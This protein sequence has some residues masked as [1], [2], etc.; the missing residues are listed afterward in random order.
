MAMLSALLIIIS[1]TP[2]A[3]SDQQ[4]SF[5]VMGDSR[6]DGKATGTGQINRSVLVKLKNQII[7]LRNS[8]TTYKPEFLVFLGDMCMDGGEANINIW[9]TLMDQP[10]S[11][12]IPYFVTFGN[13][14]LYDAV[15]IPK[16]GKQW[17]Y[18]EDFARLL[19][20]EPTPEF[21]TER[22]DYLTNL[23]FSFRKGNA[24]FVIL[25]AYNVRPWKKTDKIPLIGYISNGQ[26][27]WLEGVL[28]KASNDDSI[29]HKF[30]FSHSPLDCMTADSDNCTKS[31]Y[32][33]IKGALK[34]Y[35]VDAFFAGHDH[36]FSY[37]IYD[38]A[39]NKKGMGLTSGRAGA[40]PHGASPYQR[41]VVALDH[42]IYVK[43]DGANWYISVYGSDGVPKYQFN[44]GVKQ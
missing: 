33:P 42:F 8:L 23:A 43:I 2:A 3:A 40:L 37:Y 24:L 17:T 36:V 27:D 5:V 29:K 6:G 21:Y 39:N 7:N 12:G 38:T 10:L 22:G 9:K 34:T 41:D 30:V 11:L 44:N 16:R 31:Y 20:N 35:N 18:Q 25:D 26:Y 32:T 4:F 28:K 19:N 13:H 14:E 1:L 15:D